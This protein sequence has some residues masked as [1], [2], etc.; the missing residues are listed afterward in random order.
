MT[1]SPMMVV[2]I[3]I[4]VAMVGFLWWALRRISRF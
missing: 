3:L 1:G 4:L 2:L